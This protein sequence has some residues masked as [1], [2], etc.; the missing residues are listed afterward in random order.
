MANLLGVEA[1][2]G[3]QMQGLQVARN[4]FRAVRVDSLS[5]MQ[6]RESGFAVTMEE[7]CGSSKYL[8]KMFAEIPYRL[9]SRSQGALSKSSYHP[10]TF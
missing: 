6:L 9:T 10:A 1:Q 4:G 3:Q 8:A 7:L 5:S 2:D